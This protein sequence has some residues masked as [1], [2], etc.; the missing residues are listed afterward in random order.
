[1]R[2]ITIQ[3]PFSLALPA[4]H[5]QMFIRVSGVSNAHPLQAQTGIQNPH[6][7]SP[8]RFPSLALD[9]AIQQPLLQ[10]SQLAAQR[11]P[12]HVGAPEELSLLPGGAQDGPRAADRHERISGADSKDFGL[13]F[14]AQNLNNLLPLC[15][16]PFRALEMKI[17]EFRCKDCCF[18]LSFGHTKLASPQ[19]HLKHVHLSFPAL[20]C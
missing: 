5:N 3:T 19:L 20:I 13:Y 14:Q 12:K 17:W 18:Q 15:H 9:L 1:M 4:L 8:I 11:C 7:L 16:A 2:Y 6:F 10:S